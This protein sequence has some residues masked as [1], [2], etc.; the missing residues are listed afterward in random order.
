MEFDAHNLRQFAWKPEVELDRICR[1]QWFH[2]A[3]LPGI[4]KLGEF[5]GAYRS[6]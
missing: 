3:H 1:V 5:L 4:T 2:I 6:V